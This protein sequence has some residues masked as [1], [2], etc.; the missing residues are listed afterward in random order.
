MN[1]LNN[2]KT[3]RYKELHLQNFLYRLELTEEVK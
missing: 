2:I 3:D 1:P